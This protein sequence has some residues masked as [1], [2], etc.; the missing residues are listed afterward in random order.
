MSDAPIT[1]RTRLLL[2]QLASLVADRSR[3][4]ADAQ[5]IFDAARDEAIRLHKA[6]VTDADAHAKNQ[7]AQVDQLHNGRIDALRQSHQVQLQAARAQFEADVREFRSKTAAIEQAAQRKAEDG[8]W[9]VD[10]MVESGEGKLK[11]EFDTVRRSLQSLT[12]RTDQLAKE[13]QAELEKFSHKPLP[14]APTDVTHWAVPDEAAGMRDKCEDL[15]RQG[16]T[17]LDELRGRIR[18]RFLGPPTFVFVPILLI[19]AGAAA[20]AIA[21]GQPYPRSA[22]IGAGAG[23]AL[24]AII[25]LPLRV[26]LRG[27]VPPVAEKLSRHIA[28]TRA[29]IDHSLRVIDSQLEDRKL[30]L[31]KQAEQEVARNR[32]EVNQ[33]RYEAYRRKT[34]E[35]PVFILDHE[36]TIVELRARLEAESS[37]AVAARDDAA[38]AIKRSH[39]EAIAQ[40]DQARDQSLAAAK[41]AHDLEVEQILEKWRRG[42]SEAYASMAAIRASTADSSAPWESGRWSPFPAASRV[43]PAV[44]IG[45][46]E[47]D[48]ATLPG[49]LPDD[50]AFALPGPASFELPVPLDLRERGSVLL[51]A[52]ADGRQASLSALRNI[53]LRMLAALPP[54]KTRFTIID[55]V[56]LGESFA[57]FMHLADYD[58]QIVGDRIWTEPRHIEQKLT[59]LTEHMETVI[60]KY[61]RN[62]YATIQE[63]NEKAG[64]IAEPYRF[65]VIAD[66]P[67]GFSEAA[68]KR[69]ASI[70]A[71]GPRCGV[72]TLI[73]MD[74]RQRP[75]AWVPMADIE[76]GSTTIAIRNGKPSWNEEQFNRWPITLEAPPQDAT[77]TRLIHETGKLAKD[78]GRVQVPFETVA[79]GAPDLWTRSAAEEIRVPIGRTGATKIQH[80]ALGRGT[81]QHALI[82]GRTGSGKSTLLHA[83]ITSAALW[84]SPDEVELFLVDFKKGVEFKT[85]AVHQLP[86][87]RV[88][89]VESEREFGLSVL[90]KLDAELTRRGELYRNLGVQDLAGY[91]RAAQA[92]SAPP[93]TP[94]VMPRIL[95]IVDEFQEF[96]VAD[97]KIAQEASLLLDRLVR[98]G[99]A[100][101]VHVILGSQTIGGVYSLARST[102]GQMAVRIALQ[103]S[104]ADSYLIMSED[105]AAAR[106]L[107]RPGEAIYNDASGLVEGNSPFQV[108][109]LPDDKREK[110]LDAVHDRP[111]AAPPPLVFEGNV[112]SDLGK[113][114]LL[115]RLIDEPHTARTAL[116]RAWLGDA[117]SIKDPT[118]TTFKRQSSANLLIVGQQDLP[119]MAVTLASVISLAAWVRG[120]APRPDARPAITIFDGS[121]MEDGSPSPFEVLGRRLPAII[122]RAGVREC[123]SAVAELHED[124]VR[125]QSPDAAEAPTRFLVVYGLQRFRALRRAEEDFGFGGDGDATKPDQQFMNIIREGPALGIHTIMWINTTATLERSLDRRALREFDGRVLFQMSQTD[126]SF[127]IDGPAAANLGQHR[128]LAF[129]EETGVIEKFRPYALPDAEWFETALQTLASAQASNGAL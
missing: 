89:A 34:E 66:F 17:M 59:D 7:R 11:K 56:G 90:R 47:I 72:F 124:L 68:A 88:I 12:E 62:E 98:Q 42:M 22:L 6:A 46:L 122:T 58:Q 115:S 38:A 111:H 18:P 25:F 74:T 97:D 92:A 123:E 64:E 39:H 96:F 112:P 20:S 82:A 103:C 29:T 83:I 40:A 65:L 24:S 55:P 79:P 108:V 49:G 73:S 127:L 54:A 125:R 44:S 120:Q 8:H 33:L 100:F 50:P 78:A 52:G 119:S 104:E 114:P 107:S 19:A 110:F 113:N 35:E 28:E 128:A 116:P 85:Y 105:N 70:I 4:A 36:N 57:A 14:A 75:P 80:L 121:V 69:L 10:T 99:R 126:S 16:R 53:M 94:R 93:G 71:S 21:M 95:L 61:L 30:L 9:L 26:V 63:Y 1:R 87:A 37:S 48:L 76:R 2:A 109:W 32:L 43:P 23:A 118:A 13:A 60:Q 86:H 31:R 45:S 106:L 101:G 102:I 77:F 81:A 117:I 27:R 67:A 15:V 41:H 91:R 5:R 3:A 129:S 84:Y 51:Q